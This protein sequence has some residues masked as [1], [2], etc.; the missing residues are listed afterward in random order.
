MPPMERQLPDPLKKMRQKHAA[1]AKL[2]ASQTIQKKGIRKEQDKIRVAEATEKH[3]NQE[4]LKTPPSLADTIAK[5][6]LPVPSQTKE[7]DPGI[8]PKAEQTNEKVTTPEGNFATVSLD[9]TRSEE[10]EGDSISGNKELRND[11]NE[12]DETNSKRP[13]VP[14]HPDTAE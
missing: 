11:A 9:Y 14:L 12:E 8:L 4:R 10:R 13:K 6:N 5:Y 2:L 3:A 1:D 7:T